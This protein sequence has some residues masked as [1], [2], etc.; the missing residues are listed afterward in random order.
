MSDQVSLQPVDAANV[1]V[2][3]DNFI[4]VLLPSSEVAQRLQV[5]YEMWECNAM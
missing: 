2:L 5:S 1:T 4:D 3:V